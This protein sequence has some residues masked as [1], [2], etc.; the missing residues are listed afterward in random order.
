MMIGLMNASFVTLN[1]VI[2]PYSLRFRFFLVYDLMRFTILYFLCFL[3]SSMVTRNLLPFRRILLKALMVLFVIV[4]SMQI[5]FGVALSM[6][7]DHDP[8]YT[9]ILC[10]DPLL[11]CKRTGPFLASMLFCFILMQ[12]RSRVMDGPD[13]LQVEEARKE[14]RL[15]TLTRLQ[16]ITCIFIFTSLYLIVWDTVRLIQNYKLQPSEVNCF[17]VSANK[18]FNTTL[19]FFA[20]FFAS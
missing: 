3:Y 12:I 1:E 13:Y 20:R 6:K 5:Y 15:K 14:K 9:K 10:T 17:G 7:L 19:W 8:D 16:L 11:V 4:F 18:P 2:L